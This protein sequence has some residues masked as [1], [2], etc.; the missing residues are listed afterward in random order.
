MYTRYSRRR[1]DYIYDVD[2]HELVNGR[3]VAFVVKLER[4]AANGTVSVYA[5]IRRAYGATIS[6][7]LA[8]LEA[9]IDEWAKKQGGRM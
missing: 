9:A 5:D 6:A 8:N 7:A 3:Y 1:G 2:V 4:I